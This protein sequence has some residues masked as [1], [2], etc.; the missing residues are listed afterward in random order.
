MTTD[1]K[2]AAARV[3]LKKE[4][5]DTH[6]TAIGTVYISDVAP[7]CREYGGHTEPGSAWDEEC[8]RRLDTVIGIV[9]PFGVTA[10]WSDDD[11]SLFVIDE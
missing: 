11:V 9:S 6:E 4:G 8:H 5:Y 10:E 7:D 3:A 1:E 2:M